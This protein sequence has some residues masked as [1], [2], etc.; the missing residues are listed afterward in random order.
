MATRARGALAAAAL[1]LAVGVAPAMAAFPGANGRIA[2][3]VEKWRGADPCLPMPHGCEPQVV[4]SRIETVLPDGRGRRVMRAFAPPEGVGIN[5]GPT[6][7]PDG[8]SLALQQ[9]T[10]LATIRRD[11]TRL[12]LLPQLTISDREPTWSPDGRRL[13]FV[14][15]QLCSYCNWVYSVRP[16]GT[17]LR[18]IIQQGARFT[19]WSP[20]GTLAFVN[21]DDQGQ[22]QTG[23]DD[24]LYTVRPDG[25]RLRRVFSR[26]VGVQPDWSPDG[27]RIAFTARKHIF[28]V[29]AR[30]GTLE[31]L[32]KPARPPVRSVDPAWSPDGK[33]IAFS[34]EGDIYVMRS[35]G[36]G[37]RRIV[38]AL[39]QDPA[40]LGRAWLE[41]SGPSW[42]PLPR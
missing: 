40:R 16:D 15:E 21:W 28:T 9:G 33:W 39:R 5:P 11:G 13:A 29:G 31:R 4:S 38:H 12:R 8:R 17:G 20:T 14:G 19:A 24:G 26:Y 27:R 1:V 22:V 34:R 30:G 2:F 42:E 25:S 36:S 37:V 6:W 18:R 23:L 7:S 32:T 35:D 41:L 3:T 10:R